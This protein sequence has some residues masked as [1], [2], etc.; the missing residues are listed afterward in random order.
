MLARYSKFQPFSRVGAIKRSTFMSVDTPNPTQL[1]R[2]GDQTQRMSAS[3]LTLLTLLNLCMQNAM[4]FIDKLSND[5]LRMFRYP[6]SPRRYCSS[7]KR[8]GSEAEFR[9]IV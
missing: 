4:H 2:T 1:A 8:A 6:N 5:H 9:Q 7:G 3:I